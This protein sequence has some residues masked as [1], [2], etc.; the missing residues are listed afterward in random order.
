MAGGSDHEGRLYRVATMI[1]IIG[2]QVESAATCQAYGTHHFM[3]INFISLQRDHVLWQDLGNNRMLSPRC[4]GRLSPIAH[5]VSINEPTYRW[6]ETFLGK[7]IN[8]LIVNLDERFAKVPVVAA[9]FPIFQLDEL[10]NREESAFQNYGKD[11]IK[12]LAEHFH[13]DN[14]ELLS[15]WQKIKYNY[16]SW[17][18]TE[19]LTTESCMKKVVRLRDIFPLLSRLAEVGLA[20]PVS[21][22][23]P[24]RGV[25][26]LKRLKTRLRSRLSQKMLNSLMMISI[27]GPKPFSKDAE[28]VIKA[29]VQRW[30]SAKKRRRLPRTMMPKDRQED[31][32]TETGE[33]VAQEEG[34]GVEEE[35]EEEEVKRSGEVEVEVEDHVEEEQRALR[36]FHLEEANKDDSDSDS[37][38]DSDFFSDDD[39]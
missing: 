6:A 34:P 21:N 5:D 30:L 8:A 1:A 22:A 38:Y 25:S 39:L 7:S 32:R 9:A 3:H 2:I 17:K 4:L 10:P 29:A 37:D 11:N 19:M 31:G 33:G 13:L 35:E 14:D 28:D 12:Q 36:L 18:Q 23:W 27:N 15:K 16:L 26:C 20:L 24:E